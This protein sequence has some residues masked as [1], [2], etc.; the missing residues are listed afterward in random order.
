MHLHR[1]GTAEIGNGSREVVC[2][3]PRY[4]VYY[5]D[6]GCNAPQSLERSRC[7]FSIDRVDPVAFPQPGQIGKLSSQRA[8]VGSCRGDWVQSGGI[9]YSDSPTVG[10][11]YN[12][13]IIVLRYRY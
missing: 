8:V 1:F 13:E 2:T 9:D 6:R 10:I 4:C 5:A 11:Y 12:C 3:R 7:K